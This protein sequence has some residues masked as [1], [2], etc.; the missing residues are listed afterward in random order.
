MA[1]HPVTHGRRGLKQEE[2]LAKRDEPR[3]LHGPRGEVGHGHEVQLVVRIRSPE[4][5][6]QGLEDGGGVLERGGGEVALALRGDDSE[7]DHPAGGPDR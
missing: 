2:P 3:V 1:R 6:R 5:V 7:R 4:E